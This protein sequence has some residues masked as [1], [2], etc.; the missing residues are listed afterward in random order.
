[1]KNDDILI[2]II[3]PTYNRAALI[4]K[5]IH[6]LLN[7]TKD[8]FEI[9]I[10]D[11][12]STDNTKEVIEKIKDRRVQYIY[13]TN[14]E[15]GATRNLGAKHAK[16]R[17]I[18]FFDSD[19]IAYT[20]HTLEASKVISELNPD[21]FHLNFDIKTPDGRPCSSP[22]KIHNINKQLIK[23]NVMSCN[24]VFIKKEIALKNPFNEIRELSAS[25]DY[26]LW[27]QLASK[28]NILHSNTITSTIINHDL[29]SVLNMNQDALIA[30]K[31]LM[32]KLCLQNSS[33]TSYYK[34]N[35]HVL[36]ANT[37]SYISLHLILSNEKVNSK[38][39][40]KKAIKADF[41]FL[42]TKRFLA[43]IKRYI[44]G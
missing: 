4:D 9:I 6:S 35:L 16:G 21:V 7:Q 38:K 22:T 25:E 40:L 1:M 5:T 12:G 14:S 3:V 11:D 26:L 17:Y 15:R 43:I 33:I 18:N 42:F 28:F 31:L 44:K 13:K 20:N 36:K 19:D 2:S 27:L 30:R 41:K 10:V 37:Y 23:G 24:G 34:N 39:F 8:N 29:R 32:L